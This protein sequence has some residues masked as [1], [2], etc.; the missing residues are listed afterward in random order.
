M[1]DDVT[2]KFDSIALERDSWRKKN[3]YYHNTL[4]KIYKF[5]IPEK[6]KVLKAGCCTGGLLTQL[7]PSH[8]VGID[9]SKAAIETAND[10]FSESD[11]LEFIC[12]NAEEYKS[13]E[14]FDYVVLADTIG[15]LDDIQKVF[16]N[17]H[18][19]MT[20]RTRLVINFYNFV[21]EPVFRI[22][23]WMRLKQKEPRQNWL[24]NADVINLLE[25][26]G[27]EMIHREGFM[28]IPIYIPLLSEIFNGF[29]AK[30][31]LIKHLTV[32]QFIIARPVF[33]SDKRYNPSVSVVVPARNE[34]GNIE[35]AVKRT[36][37]MGEWMEIIFVEGGSSDNTWE[38][39][40]RVKE[41]FPEKKI[42]ITK[43]D[44]KGKGDAVRK[45]FSLAEGEVLMILDADLTMPPEEL[46]KFYKAISEDKGEFINGVRL[47]Y[48]MEDQAM[49][50]LNLYG[51]KFFSIIFT[52]ILGQNYK[53]TLCGTKVLRKS[54]YEKIARN[55]TYFGDFDP[56]GD[57]DLIFGAAK[58]C[59]K[60]VQLPIK[61]RKRTY[62]ETNISR[63]SGGWLLLRM[64]WLGFLKFKWRLR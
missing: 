21:W 2:T 4:T 12:A 18:D 19:V 54:D 3:S 50:L 23:E 61:Y 25:L 40:V 32:T 62:G 42:K 46:P 52:Y 44:G 28:L 38:E 33:I 39:I 53:D 56:Y 34:A 41:K 7:N 47:V 20:P 22:A 57:F 63:F 36:P 51:N 55:R 24:S 31:P 8:G 49:R 27:Y 13:K 35:L 15:Y 6:Q 30:L 64:A 43:Q 26:S 59:L 10:K 60:T 5:F 29:L 9:I 17:L 48:P 45:G 37:E 14:K 16:E 1:K 11:N 58:L